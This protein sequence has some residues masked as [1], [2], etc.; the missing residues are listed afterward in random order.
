V[1]WHILCLPRPP[2]AHKFKSLFVKNCKSWIASQE[3][4]KSL[5]DSLDI[6]FSRLNEWKNFQSCYTHFLLSWL[7]GYFLLPNRKYPENVLSVGTFPIAQQEMSRHAK[8]V[9]TFPVGLSGY[10][11]LPNRKY[12]DT[13]K[14]RDISYWSCR[15]I[16]GWVCRDK[17]G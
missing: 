7:S 15:D 11:L 10:F 1:L 16:S 17:Y 13:Q 6:F 2:V 4:Q 8:S 5:L 9:G 3:L 12:P 14:C